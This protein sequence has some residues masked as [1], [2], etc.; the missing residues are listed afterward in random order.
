MRRVHPTIPLL[1]TVTLLAGCSSGSLLGGPASNSAQDASAR[2]SA[3]RC[4]AL[5][6]EPT[7]N[8]NPAGVTVLL[9]DGSASGFTRGDGPRSRQDWATVLSQV[10]PHD[11]NDL[12][13]MGL[14]GGGVDWKFQTLTAGKSS[15]PARTNNDQ[16]DTRRCLVGDLSDAMSTPPG[17]PQ[18]DVLR[19][20]TEGAEYVR[21]RPGNKTIYIATD[22]LSN[23]G[24]ADLRAAPIGDLTAIPGM[25][26]DCKSELPTLGKNY[27]I[28]F[29]GIGN[30]ANGWPDIKTPQRTW[31]QKLW[32]AFCIA[33]GAT[34]DDPSSAAP[35][36]VPVTDVKLPPDA[37]VAMPAITKKPGNP[38]LLS[39]P[40]SILFDIDKYALAN[41]RAQDALQQIMD[42]LNSVHYTK[43]VIDG[44]TDSTGTPEQNRTLSQQRADAVADFLRSRHFT[45]ITTV[46]YGSTQPACTPEYNNGQP[47]LINMA[48]NRR[49]EILVYI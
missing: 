10:L 16:K 48:C 2:P 33:T 12:V 4:S 34:C 40:A 15:D 23:T 47:D 17:K 31:M 26:E 36:S 38:T 37:D 9:A 46:G 49:V 18:T 3:Q 19:A 13:A 6:T 25:V 22:G 39:V 8:A 45:N 27:S 1:A 7:D 21:S 5:L 30:P 32:K 43:I 35:G 24:C 44:H 29:L 41:D 28:H 20:L 14:F 42:F 11:G